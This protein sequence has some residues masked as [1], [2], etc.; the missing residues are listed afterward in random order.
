MQAMKTEFDAGGG[1]LKTF[2][3]YDKNIKK[4]IKIL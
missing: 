2:E 1:G 3:Q 4:V